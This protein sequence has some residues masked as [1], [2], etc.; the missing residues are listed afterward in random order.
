[1]SVIVKVIGSNPSSDEYEG[2]QRLKQILDTDLPQNAIGEIILHANAT[3]VGQ[4][5]KDID[6]LMLGTLQNCPAVVNYTDSEDK[7]AKGKVFFSS[8]CTAIEIKSHDITGIVRE[9]TEFYVKY[10]RD[11]HPATTQSNAQKISVKNYLE[12]ST[13]YSPF[14]TNI[15]WFT[16]ISEEELKVLLSTDY[17]IMPS[18]VL[19]SSF[20]AQVL[21]QRLVWQKQ[22]RYYRGAYYFDCGINT[23]SVEDL[24]KVFHKFSLAKAGMG[25]LTRKRIE[26]I[27]SNAIKPTIQKPEEGKISIY[28]GRAGTGKT[29]GLIQLAISLV[30]EEDARVLILTYNRALVS[31]LKRLFA[32]AELPDLFSQSCVSI[33]TMHSFFFRIANE[34]LFN[35]TLEGERFLKDYEEILKK[36]L[37]FLEGGDD[38]LELIREVMC[39]DDYLNWDYCMIDEAQDWLNV[40]QDIILKLFA[41]DKIIVADGGQQFVRRIEPGD[42]SSVPNRKSTKLKYC[43][44]QKSNLIRFINRYLDEMGKSEFRLADPGKISGGRVVICGETERRFGVFKEELGH[45]KSAGNIPYDMLFL[46]PN[47][48][49]TREPRQF[50]E[51]RLY[52][53]HGF[54]LWDGTNEEARSTYSQLGDEERVLQYDSSRGLEAW[55]V[56]CVSFDRFI[57]EK[58][59]SPM[60]HLRQESLYL[61]SAEDLR[62]KNLINWL[63]IPLT[64]A[65]D[66]IVITISD[67]NSPTAKLLK[68]LAREN[69]DYVCLMEENI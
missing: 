4:T 8:F 66:T 38:A 19:A 3:L 14:V 34:V 5:I 49:V 22:P 26:Q 41:P 32:L 64:R 30:D 15:L 44:R 36:L 62:I 33:N 6:I 61:E 27:T 53:E 12:R 35:G 47:T 57:E 65:I 60:E 40:E 24:A 39:S 18:N 54:S 56:V 13:G 9:G 31:D 59:S 55:T 43:L 21:L 46:V 28:R 29:V 63:L 48:M 51:K 50:M 42:W 25:A 20:T 69:S 45:L 23:L 1:M 67:W 52:E 37:C 58:G 68:K 10:G 17:G 16:G 7:S 2:A 11:L